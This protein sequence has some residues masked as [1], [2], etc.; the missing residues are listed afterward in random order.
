MYQ[1]QYLLEG[2]KMSKIDKKI[3][4]LYDKEQ[5]HLTDKLA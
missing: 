3:C 1:V 4:R 2:L 5:G